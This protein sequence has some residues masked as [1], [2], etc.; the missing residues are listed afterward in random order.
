M[1][2]SY[3]CRSGHAFEANFPVGAAARTLPCR[4]ISTVTAPCACEVPCELYAE[5][6]FAAD[7]A[8]VTIGIVDPYRTFHLGS[9][10]TKAE[11]EQQRALDA[12]RDNFERKRLERDFGRTYIGDDVGCLR[13]SGQLGIEMYREQKGQIRA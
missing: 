8:G 3:R 1:T 12:P 11:G 9:K 6:D 7:F 2:Y 10:A 4:G 13:K 5:R